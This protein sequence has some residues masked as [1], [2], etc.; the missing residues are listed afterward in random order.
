MLLKRT[1]RKY[2][3]VDGDTYNKIKM[4]SNYPNPFNPSTNINFLLSKWSRVQIEVFDI[5]GQKVS[6]LEDKFLEAGYHTYTFNA[7]NL[8]SGTY[9]YR[10][11]T[12]GGKLGSPR[13]EIYSKK[14]L[15]IK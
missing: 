15:Y 6:T 7:S 1:E 14:M 13:L 10:I 12:P 8:S 5:T 3:S 2:I 4:H 11:K 9:I